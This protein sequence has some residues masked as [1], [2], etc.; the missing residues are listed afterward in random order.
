MLIIKYVLLF[1]VAV[2]FWILALDHDL[3]LVRDEIASIALSDPAGTKVA[4]WEQL[5]MD[6][7]IYRLN[8]FNPIDKHGS[9]FRC[10]TN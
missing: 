7:G 3:R 5:S 6:E 8:I 2:T 10:Y 4:I 1:F 9:P